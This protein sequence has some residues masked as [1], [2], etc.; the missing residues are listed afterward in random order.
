MN[1]FFEQFYLQSLG[2]ASYLV[3]DEKTGRALVFDPRRDVEVYLRAAREQGLRISY[4]ADSHGHNDYLSGLSELHARAGAQL[5]G[6][7]RPTSST[8][9]VAGCLEQRGL[10]RRAVRTNTST[11]VRRCTTVNSME[12]VEVGVHALER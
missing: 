9:P 7:A 10:P 3:G 6:S 11:C 8:S 1:V 4:A 12:R 2:Q 5:W